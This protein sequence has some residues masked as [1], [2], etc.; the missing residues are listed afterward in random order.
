MSSDILLRAQ[1]LIEAASSIRRPYDGAPLVVSVDEGLKLL[2]EFANLS[3]VVIGGDVWRYSDERFDVVLDW[4]CEQI[5]GESSG[6][7]ASRSIDVATAKLSGPSVRWG[8]DKI[9]VDFVVK[10]GVTGE[11]LARL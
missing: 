6:E 8:A 4:Y 10:D 11:K 1:F 2:T 3:L 7:F 9:F 5:S